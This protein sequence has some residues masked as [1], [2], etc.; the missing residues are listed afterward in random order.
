MEPDEAHPNWVR[1]QDVD[2][3]VVF[4]LK[5]SQGEARGHCKGSGGRLAEVHS[6][7]QHNLLLYLAKRY[8]HE[9]SLSVSQFM[10]GEIVVF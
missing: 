5:L 9:A 6:E 7:D 3:E 2:Y 1:H 4:D 10:L 8:R